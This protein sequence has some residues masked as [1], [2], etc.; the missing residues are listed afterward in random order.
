MEF[1]W[2]KSQRPVARCTW[3]QADE[4]V[5]STTPPEVGGGPVVPVYRVWLRTADL[6]VLRIAREA[7]TGEQVIY[8]AGADL[9]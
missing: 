2:G 6:Y 1:N 4:A 9:Q 3:S 8:I 7:Q 5:R